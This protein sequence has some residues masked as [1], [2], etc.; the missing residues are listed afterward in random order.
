MARVTTP[1]LKPQLAKL[2]VFIGGFVQENGFAPSYEEM[3]AGTGASSKSVVRGR[4]LRLEKDGYVTRR[5]ETARAVKLLD[6]KADQPE[7]RGPS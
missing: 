5:P 1:P 4:I 3:R 2:L 6:S 7:R